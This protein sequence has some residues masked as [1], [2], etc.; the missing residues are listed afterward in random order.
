MM[1][2]LALATWPLRRPGDLWRNNFPMKS[3]APR[4]IDGSETSMLRVQQLK[5]EKEVCSELL[6]LSSE[7]KEISETN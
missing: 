1:H 7:P 5:R 4:S 6:K 3:R 2:G